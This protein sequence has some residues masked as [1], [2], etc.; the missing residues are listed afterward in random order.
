MA[1]AKHSAKASYRAAAGVAPGEKSRNHPPDWPLLGI[2]VAG[3]LL[4]A[5]LSYVAWFDVPLAYCSA[6]SSCDAVQ[7]SRWSRLFGL[8][9][10]FWG[11]LTYL[12]LAAA[13]AYRRSVVKRYRLALA[14]AMIG[15]GVSIYLNAVSTLVIGA[16]C[17][18]CL[19]SFALLLGAA[20]RLLAWPPDPVH[21]LRA[22]WATQGLALAGVALI[23]MQL[24]HGGFL[25]PSAGPRDP[26]RQALA[27]H[28]RRIDAKFYGA[29]WCAHCQQQKALFGASVDSL[30]YIECTPNGRGGPP[31]TVCLQE[32][33][34]NFPTWVIHGRQYSQVLPIDELARIA[35]FEFEAGSE[36]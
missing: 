23:V 11:L 5:Y 29:S 25:D 17:G 18:Y 27:E 32:N 33:I 24:Y 10:A 20:I 14:I 26:Y 3:S 21:A 30:P 7:S 2:A 6:G 22:A 12:L 13:A 36:K 31:A 8:P 28:L 1:K 16:I 35:R 9:I 4:T 19:L 34:S 15:N